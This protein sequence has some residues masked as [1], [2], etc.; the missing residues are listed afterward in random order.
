MK[1]IS[2]ERLKEYAIL[3]SIPS[4]R[5]NLKRV[6]S[7][8]LETLLDY[9]RLGMLVAALRYSASIKGDVIEFGS[10]RGGS[11]GL[12]LQYLP[13]DKRIHVC[14]S[15]EGMPDVV[16]EDNFHRKGDFSDTTA[17]RVERG[18]R[19]LSSN[20]QLHIGFFKQTLQ[21]MEKNTDLTFSFA[22]IDVDLYESVKEA[23]EFCYSRM[24]HG[25]VIIFD[26]YG[27]PTCLGAK[28]AVDEFFSD[29]REE[30]VP[31]SEPAHGCIVGGGDAFRKLGKH[32]GP[33]TFLQVMRDWIFTK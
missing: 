31:L 33:L 9:R 19:S 16:E 2:I 28:Q 25:S 26:D 13:S 6:Q 17:E 21:V 27:A 1:H 32:L 15:F 12:M 23:L 4:L 20:F 5:P 22:H 3:A 14:D 11:A 7:E 29:K 8:G 24:G 10:F 30:I 18:L